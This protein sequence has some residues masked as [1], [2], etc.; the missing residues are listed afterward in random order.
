LSTPLAQPIIVVVAVDIGVLPPSQTK[1]SITLEDHKLH[2]DPYAFSGP[3]EFVTVGPV[4]GPL[5][6][7][8]RV[9]LGDAFS[10]SINARGLDL[11]VFSGAT[12]SA[13][14]AGPVQYIQCGCKVE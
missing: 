1:G 13:G 6:F 10:R 11:S 9:R 4:I 3:F 2:L 7:F 14:L 12:G 5:D 8:T